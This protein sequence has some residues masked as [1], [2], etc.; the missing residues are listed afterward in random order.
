MDYAPYA[1]YGLYVLAI[2]GA[3]FAWRPL[4]GV[5]S[6]PQ[7]NIGLINKKFVLFGS[8]K[9]LPGGRIIALKG[10]AGVAGGHARTWTLFWLLAMAVQRQ[11]RPSRDEIPS[12]RY[13][14]TIRKTIF[15]SG[16]RYGVDGMLQMSASLM[17]RVY[18]L[19][20]RHGHTTKSS[21]KAPSNGKR[22][23]HRCFRRPL[24]KSSRIRA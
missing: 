7:G 11:A 8:N 24:E 4:L 19:W 15:R 10:E 16:N 3:A 22:R 18:L 5:V 12:T 9:T 21:V 2:I 17:D 20:V 1:I 23:K 6:I 14:F 13:P